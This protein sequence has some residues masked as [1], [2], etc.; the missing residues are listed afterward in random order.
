MALDGQGQLI[1]RDAGPV[2]G[3]LHQGP[4]GRG[5]FHGDGFCA[6]VQGIFHQFLYHRGGTFHHFPGGDLRGNFRRQ[7]AD[8]H[9][10]II[11]RL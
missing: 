1:C 9:A 8:G 11:Y 3:H 4:A 6:G 5:D 7:D 10:C 2:I